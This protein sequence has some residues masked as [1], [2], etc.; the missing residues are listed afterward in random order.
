MCGK[1]TVS[2][3]IQ[4]RIEEDVIVNHKT[5][6]VYKITDPSGSNP[7][8]AKI[9]TG[10]DVELLEQFSSL[11]SDVGIPEYE[12]IR[13]NPSIQIMQPVSGS[14]LSKLLPKYLLPGIWSLR[15]SQLINAFEDLGRKIGRLHAETVSEPLQ[16]DPDSLAFDRYNAIRDGK[17]AEPLRDMLG[18]DIISELSRRLSRCYEFEVPVALVHGDLMLFHVY[19]RNSEITL[20]DLDAAKHVPVIEDHVR[21][22]CALELLFSRLPYARSFQL[23]QL[24]FAFEQGYRQ[25]GPEYELETEIWE[26]MRAVRHCSMLLYYHEKLPKQIKWK[27]RLLRAVDTPILKKRISDLLE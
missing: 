15:R 2:E 18:N 24:K 16:L 19:V 12:L 23:D 10:P 4:S 27:L 14:S 22:I 8:Y 1:D 20:I 6:S 17:I 13:G 26:T 21:F 3:L 11:E 7:R 25:T 9:W 5:Q